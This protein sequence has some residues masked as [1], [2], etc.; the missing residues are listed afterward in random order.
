[1]NEKSPKQKL[2]SYHNSFMSALG[3]RKWAIEDFYR[4][5]NL[6]RR[7]EV[8]TQN[9]VVRMHF[10]Y[11]LDE[12]Y[13]SEVPS[14]R[15]ITIAQAFVETDDSQVAFNTK[16]HLTPH[17]YDLPEL[18]GKIALKTT[19]ETDDQAKKELETMFDDDL[20]NPVHIKIFQE[21]P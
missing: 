3:A 12:I 1:M 14:E 17:I 15:N 8:G 18:M 21:R 7:F 4:R 10:L 13:R 20:Y 2:E 16:E 5:P 19:G 6:W 9:E 11:Y